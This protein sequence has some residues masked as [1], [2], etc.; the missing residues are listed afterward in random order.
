MEIFP[1]YL[2]RAT[3]WASCA[4]VL[5]ISVVRRELIELEEADR[6]NVPTTRGL[7]SGACGR[8]SRLRTSN[9]VQG[10]VS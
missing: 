4:V 3:I 7:R 6:Y 10:A 8:V 9:D 5:S 1:R 2:Q